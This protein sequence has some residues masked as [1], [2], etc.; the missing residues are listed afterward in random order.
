MFWAGNPE[1]AAHGYGGNDGRLPTPVSQA[2]KASTSA[3]IVLGQVMF[4]WFAD[5][6][7][8]RR[9]YGVELGIIILSTFSCALISPSNSISFTGLMI[10]WRVMMGVGIGGDYPLSSVITAE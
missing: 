6:F 10:F 9:M 1:E 5:M 2:L 8:R 4:G 7:G 3:G